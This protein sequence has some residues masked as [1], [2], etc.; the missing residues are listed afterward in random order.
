MLI[1]IKKQKSHSGKFKYFLGS[2]AG[3]KD[4]IAYQE[5]NNEGTETG[6]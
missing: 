1:L 5:V 3:I 4:N 6:Q 2:E